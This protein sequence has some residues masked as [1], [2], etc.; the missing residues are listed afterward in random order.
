MVN[1][2][3][4][5]QGHSEKSP[6]CSPPFQLAT[7]KA[8]VVRI[9]LESAL[10]ANSKRMKTVLNLDVWDKFKKTI[11]IKQVCKLVDCSCSSCR[12]QLLPHF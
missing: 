6:A 10:T 2:E 3:V 1:A 9:L 12:W 11:D 7:L 8:S 5:P 4:L